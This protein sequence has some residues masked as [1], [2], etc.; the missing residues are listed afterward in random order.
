M[1][2]RQLSPHEIFRDCVSVGT[3][4]TLLTATLLIGKWI[5]AN[6]QKWAGQSDVNIEQKVTNT[7]LKNDVDILK[8]WK[9]ASTQKPFNPDK[10]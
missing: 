4:L 3:L 5:G 9:V 2:R 8:Q 6:D 10:Q 7:Q 1:E